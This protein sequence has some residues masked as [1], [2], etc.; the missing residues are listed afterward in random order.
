VRSARARFII[1]PYY[2]YIDVVL[3]LPHWL[4]THVIGETQALLVE[5]VRMAA[6]E[7]RERRP[8]SKRVLGTHGVT[9]LWRC[10]RAARLAARPVDIDKDRLEGP[11]W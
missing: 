1:T 3:W 11:A 4:A 2:T 6:L 7:V 5:P 9:V 10:S 8:G